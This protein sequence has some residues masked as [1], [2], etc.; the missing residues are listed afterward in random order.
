MITFIWIVS[1]SS[2]IASQVIQPG[3]DTV[4]DLLW[5]DLPDDLS[6][7]LVAHKY[8]KMSEDCKIIKNI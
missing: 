2:D 4:L 5:L 8:V 6:L 3:R 7:F 1:F